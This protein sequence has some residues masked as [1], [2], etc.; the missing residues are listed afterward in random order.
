MKIIFMGT[1]MYASV[2][3]EALLQKHEVVALIAQEDK[4][5]GRNMQLKMPYTKE[6]LFNKGLN[7]KIPIFQPSK[8]DEGFYEEI[9]KIACDVIIVAAYGKIL[10]KKI[11]SLAP[12]INLHASILPKYR[13]ASPIQSAILEEEEYFGVTAMKME[14]G[15]DCGEILGISAFKNQKEGAVELFSKLS[16]EAAKLTLELL[17]FGIENISPLKQLECNKSLCKKIKKEEGRVELRSAKEVYLK[18]LAYEGWPEISL[19]NQIKLKNIHL[20]EE[21]SS[22]LEGVILQIQKDKI[23][24]GCKKGSIFVEIIQA[25]SKKPMNAYDYL[26][27]KRLKVGDILS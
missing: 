24:L 23:L 13:G 14:E 11:L 5:A 9:S 4:R 10:P 20:N 17:E 12:C 15:L 22:N 16:F 21:D 1:P 6:L 7:E 3:L 8:L 25:P 27:G 18:S 19:A 26:Q 2:I